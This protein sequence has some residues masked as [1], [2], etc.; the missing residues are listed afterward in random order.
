MA[1]SKK[2]LQQMA[3]VLDVFEAAKKGGKVM[4]QPFIKAFLYEG[5]PDA[6]FIFLNL[7]RQNPGFVQFN[8]PAIL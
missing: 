6:L 1:G 3:P 7:K 8:F 5:Y 4:P 2:G